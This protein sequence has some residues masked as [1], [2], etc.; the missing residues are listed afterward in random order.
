[1]GCA[2]HSSLSTTVPGGEESH[3]QQCKRLLPA[4]CSG[5]LLPSLPEILR[6]TRKWN[7]K[8]PKA[9][10]PSEPAPG[11]RETLSCGAPYGLCWEVRPLRGQ[12]ERLVPSE[13]Y[14]LG[15]HQTVPKKDAQRDFS[16]R[17][18]SPVMGRRRCWRKT[19]INS[20]VLERVFFF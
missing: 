7:P 5:F 11:F 13:A 19:S 18:N 16:G 2:S 14:V 8:A 17:S 15:T 6:G 9:L 10:R 1:M 12:Q 4:Q 3:I 20:T